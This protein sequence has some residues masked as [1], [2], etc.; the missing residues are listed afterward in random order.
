[1]NK[2]WLQ[3]R[4][5]NHIISKLKQNNAFDKTMCLN[6]T[7]RKHNNQYKFCPQYEDWEGLDS[8]EIAC[9]TDQDSVELR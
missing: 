3:Q 7:S 8:Q 9:A 4:K 2:I 6:F 1:M 5:K